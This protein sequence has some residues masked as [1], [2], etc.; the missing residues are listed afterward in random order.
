MLDSE[1]IKEMEEWFAKDRSSNPF[2][3]DIEIF[4]Y[5]PEVILNDTKIYGEPFPEWMKEVANHFGERVKTESYDGI[6]LGISYTYIDY[7]YIVQT[8]DGKK[9]YDSCVGHIE[10]L[11]DKNSG[12]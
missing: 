8:P 11:E 3:E 9:H 10:Y 2:D 4:V 7:Y 6:L 5:D 1:Y 12:K